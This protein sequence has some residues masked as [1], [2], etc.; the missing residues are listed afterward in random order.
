MCS[1]FLQKS[2]LVSWYN[3]AT[4]TS[5]P[6]LTVTLTTAGETLTA[7]QSDVDQMHER[8]EF[9]SFCRH[10]MS[11]IYPLFKKKH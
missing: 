10:L 8:K 5:M 3:Q 9:V 6:S 4:R 11:M 7:A 1:D 2:F